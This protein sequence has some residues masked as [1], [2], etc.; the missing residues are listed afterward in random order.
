MLIKGIYRVYINVY[1]G[2]LYDVI[3][4]NIIINYYYLDISITWYRNTWYGKIALF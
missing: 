1:I 4:D 2:T 3:Y